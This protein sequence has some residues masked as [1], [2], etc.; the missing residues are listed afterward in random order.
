VGERDELTDESRPWSVQHVRE[1]M[2]QFCETAYPA[3]WPPVAEMRVSTAIR[4]QANGDVVATFEELAEQ[5]PSIWQ[6]SEEWREHR[7]QN[8]EDRPSTRPLGSTWSHSE[9]RIR[10][11]PDIADLVVDHFKAAHTERYCAWLRPCDDT[12]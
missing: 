7:G 9:L 3:A 6:Q 12:V 5:N 1:A 11:E 2:T 8:G 10:R 4:V